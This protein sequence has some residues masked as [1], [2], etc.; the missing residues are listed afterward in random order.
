MWVSF[1]RF[2]AGAAEP[3]AEPDQAG[4]FPVFGGEFAENICTRHSEI[5]GICRGDWQR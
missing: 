5:R 3:A 2:R 1:G 4:D